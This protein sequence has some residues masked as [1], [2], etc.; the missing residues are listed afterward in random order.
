[1]P[2]VDISKLS[3]DGSVKVKVG[4]III[5][6]G[7]C[8]Q[9]C[10]CTKSPSHLILTELADG[11]QLSVKM[12]SNGEITLGELKDRFENA[13]IQHFRSNEVKITIEIEGGI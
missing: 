10:I 1:M 12:D 4:D 7:E 8:E 2:K 13:S 9:V 6:N 11:F 3:K 5:I